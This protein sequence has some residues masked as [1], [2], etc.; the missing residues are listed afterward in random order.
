MCRYGNSLV[1]VGNQELRE[2]AVLPKG[3][4]PLLDL[5]PVQY[6]LLEVIAQAR[7]RGISRPYVTSKY[8]KV[9]A[10]STFF[11]VQQ[12]VKKGLI[13]I[14]VRSTTDVS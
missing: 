9:D 13:I 8:L 14:K 1:L 10:R 2:R 12:L 5:P 3:V 11:Y 6:A 4:S 7:H